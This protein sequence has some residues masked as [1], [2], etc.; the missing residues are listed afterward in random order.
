[1][2][3]W[4]LSLLATL[5]FI[6]S[7]GLAIGCGCDD[8]DD[9][10]DDGDDDAADDDAADDDAADDDAADD[11]AGCTLTDI[12]T[13]AYNRCPGNDGWESIEECA[14]DEGWFT[15]CTGEMDT[16][17]YLDCVCACF[18]AEDSCEDFINNCEIAC[19]DASCV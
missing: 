6:L 14:G 8:D 16:A 12:C 18:D 19:W 9:D 7:L 10:D 4:K 15:R 13:L 5:A 1:M 17:T 2:S 11:D 3:L